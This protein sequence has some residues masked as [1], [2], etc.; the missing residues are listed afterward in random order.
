MFPIESYTKPATLK[1]AIHILQHTS[2]APQILAGGTDLLVKLRENLHPAAYVDVSG[3]PELRAESQSPEG[4]LCFGAAR[5]FR[6][7]R[8]SP[9]ACAHTPLLSQAAD[10]VAGPQ[11][12][13]MGTLGGNICNGAVSADMV[14]PLLVLDAALVIF[15]PQGWRRT[16]LAGFHTGPGKVALQPAEILVAVEIQA[17]AYQNAR[18][19][20]HKYAMRAT[21]DI[22]T[23]GCAASV[24]LREQEGPPV[25]EALKLAFTVAAPTPVRCPHAETT[26]RGLVFDANSLTQIADA[27]LLDVNP[28]SSWRAEK[29]FRLHIIHTLVSRVLCQATGLCV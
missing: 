10:T 26:A 8:E 13:N 16:P 25:F 19:A 5:T 28:R 24:V 1:E 6:E 22:A 17:Q 11:I 14:A 2:P 3:I 29:D 9:L 7:I 18:T 27:A 4:T 20:Y 21:M 23:V 15:G 12:R